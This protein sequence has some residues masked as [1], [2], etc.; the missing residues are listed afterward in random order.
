MIWYVCLCLGMLLLLSAGRVALNERLGKLRSGIALLLLLAAT[1]V[2]YIPAFLDSYDLLSALLANTVNVMQ[3]ISLDAD[4]LAVYDLIRAS[5]PQTLLWK[6]YLLLLGVIH[7]L[8]P[9]TAAMTAFTFLL[10][11]ITNVQALFADR[12]GG[13]IYIFSE[14]NDGSEALARDIRAAHPKANLVF[15]GCSDQDSLLKLRQELHCIVRYDRICAWKS[16][17]KSGE[18]YYFCISRDEDANLDDALL[19]LDELSKEEET[20]QRREHLY[21]FSER[22]E[23]ETMIDSAEKGCVDL[24][25]IRKSRMAAYRLLDQHPLYRGAKDGRISVLL[26]GFGRINRAVLKAA[27]W[28]GQLDG[29]SLEIK[30]F[31]AGAEQAE[32]AL[33]ADCPGLFSER[34]R[35][36][37]YEGD[38]LKDIQAQWT[39]AAQSTY[40]T[41]DLGNDSVNIET[42]LFLRRCFYSV[43]GDYTNAPGIF[44]YIAGANKYDTVRRLMTPEANRARQRSYEIVPFGG[45]HEF[46]TCAV[47]VDSPIERLAKNVHLVYEDIF[48]D[49]EIDVAQ[50]MERYNAFEVNKQSNR[51]NALHIRY[52][53]SLLGLDYTDCAD[54]EEVQMEDY[55]N[56]ENME[57]LTRAEHDRWMAFLESE[58]WQTASIAEVEAY[59]RSGLSAGRHSCPLLKRHPYIC[60][61]DE[62][63]ERSDALGLPD[64][65]V[66]DRELIARIPDILH[67]RWKVAGKAYKIVKTKNTSIE[68]GYE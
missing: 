21:L 44:V 8:L 2:F 10:H 13:D 11:Y 50:A 43:G 63:K 4:Y 1:Y 33:R 25:L 57:R 64:S 31:C 19:L 65:T 24:H 58:G 66:Y 37:F 60:S 38:S 34:Y 12:R 28:C 20:I 41:V 49:G 14:L 67:D 61:Y 36:R 29:Y 30:V 5:L 47:L 46:Y 9:V 18:I 7:I 51:A 16:R 15:A 68:K 42:A 23:V 55:L 48:S 54:A 45:D 40:I 17:K 3:V 35:I 22:G 27:V 6:L 53:L 39:H 56:E 32:A 26:C 52:K 62:L 59:Q